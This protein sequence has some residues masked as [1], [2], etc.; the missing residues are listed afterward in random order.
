M[1]GGSCSTDGVLYGCHSTAY[2]LFLSHGQLTPHPFATAF[3]IFISEVEGRQ[4]TC[5]PGYHVDSHLSIS[6]NARPV[7]K[8]PLQT[9]HRSPTPGN[10]REIALAIAT[11]D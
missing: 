6:H 5:N 7:V 8:M 4:W 10:A 1:S 9:K 2:R 3:D 11:S